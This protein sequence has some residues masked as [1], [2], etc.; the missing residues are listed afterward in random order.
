M[1]CRVLL[2]GLIGS[3]TGRGGE[4]LAAAV[5][6]VG[7]DQSSPGRNMGE[8]NDDSINLARESKTRQSW[9]QLSFEPH[10]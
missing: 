4:P 6:A 5:E 2:N 7:L 8:V 3:R 1:S 10:L 9:L